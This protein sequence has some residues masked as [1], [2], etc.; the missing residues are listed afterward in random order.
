MTTSIRTIGLTLALAAPLAL[1]PVAGGAGEADVVSA[2][3]SK[4]G[5]GVYR[6][7]VT[8]RHADTGWEHYANQWDVLAPDG[9]V[10]GTRVL[11]HPHVNEQ[12]FTRGL[13]GVEI[14]DGIETVTLRAKDS[15]H[16]YGGAEVTLD[17]PR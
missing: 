4:T 16:E 6:F 8:V 14:P 15:Q 13:G 7:D 12:P 17:L 2:T 9:S 1:S 11:H 3:V 5:P 10:L